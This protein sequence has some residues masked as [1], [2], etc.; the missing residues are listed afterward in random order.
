VPFALPLPPYTRV[1]VP[2]WFGDPI[3][4]TFR[5]LVFGLESRDTNEKFNIEAIKN[6]IYGAAFGA[7]RWNPKTTVTRKPQLKYFRVFEKLIND[8][9]VFI[10]FSD[11]VKTFEVSGHGK[12]FDDRQARR[13]F[14]K[15]AG[16]SNN[17]QIL[18]EEIRLIAPHKILCLGKPSFDFMNH[19]KLSNGSPLVQI[20]HPSQGGESEAKKQIEQIAHEIYPFRTERGPGVIIG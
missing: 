9:K 14:K 18:Q 3:D 2:V 8:P 13:G 19:A 15:I 1:D 6:R 10:V 11:I 20:R 17:L 5:I 7:D 4:C 16:S 12:E